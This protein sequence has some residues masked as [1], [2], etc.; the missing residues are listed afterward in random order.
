MN[1]DDAERCRQNLYLLD[2]FNVSDE[3]Y[4]ELTMT[5]NNLP[6]LFKIKK[7]LAEL[8]LDI[9]ISKTPG[10]SEGVSTSFVSRLEAEV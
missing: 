7:L 2:W 5:S 8:N 6:R 3:A 9:E 10:N 4:Y 1:S